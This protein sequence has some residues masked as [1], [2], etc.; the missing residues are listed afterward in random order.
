MLLSL[1]ILLVA[2]LV[3]TLSVLVQYTKDMKRRKHLQRKVEGIVSPLFLLFVIYLLGWQRQNIA[4]VVL[5]VAAVI[6]LLIP[7]MLYPFSPAA[8]DG[9]RRTAR[10]SQPNLRR[11]QAHTHQHQPGPDP[12]QHIPW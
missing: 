5:A 4:P 10:R 9:P 11:Q 3:A 7:L 8:K 12:A 2:T 1:A 6:M